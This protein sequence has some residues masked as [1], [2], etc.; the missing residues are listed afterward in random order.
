MIIY[1]FKYT[2]KNDY[3]SESFLQ[4]KNNFELVNLS[5]VDL[6]VESIAITGPNGAGK[7]TFLKLISG[8]I[9]SQI[10]ITNIKY[11]SILNIDDIRALILPDA[12]IQENIWNLVC[13]PIF[14]YPDKKEAIA[15]ISLEME[16]YLQV[17]YKFISNG[18]R[19][20]FLMKM[21]PFLKYDVLVIDEWIG[22]IDAF[23]HQDRDVLDLLSSKQLIMSSHNEVLIN[24][25][26]SK[27]L[28][29]SNGIINEVS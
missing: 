17:P 21:L 5:E 23:Y 1:P 8:S 18:W 11:Q 27:K 13:L 6:G 28:Y 14:S 20:R 10:P 16:E 15:K 24:R 19:Q 3:L 25:Y 26:T 29:I 12:L 7:S 9:K 2:Y 4:K 22:A